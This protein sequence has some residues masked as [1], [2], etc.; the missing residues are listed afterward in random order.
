M[1]DIDLSKQYN[2]CSFC[3]VKEK[4]STQKSKFLCCSFLL[5]F[6]RNFHRNV[7]RACRNKEGCSESYWQSL[8]NQVTSENQNKQQNQKSKNKRSYK[9][10]KVTS[11]LKL[12][13]H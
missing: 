12:Q 4:R 2:D 6:S 9:H 10:I 5:L 3:K 7:G 1:T 13:A 8:Y 11:T